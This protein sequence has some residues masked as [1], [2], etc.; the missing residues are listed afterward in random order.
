MGL[1]IPKRLNSVPLSAKMIKHQIFNLAQN[2]RKQ[3]IASIE[4][5]VHFALQLNETANVSND[6]QLMVYVRYR[7]V[8]RIEEE[9]LFCTPL[10]LHTRGID[11]FRKAN[12]FFFK[13]EEVNLEW[14][15][16]AGVSEDGTPL[17]L[18]RVNSFAALAQK[19]NFSIQYKYS[20]HGTPTS[21]SCEGTGTR[22]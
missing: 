5:S 14:R 7:G 9:M 16:C 17:T 13:S 1:N 3:V 20:L 10:E 8:D 15:N 19:E 22:A 18:G 11:V 12:A 4:S 6:S 2:V 21:A